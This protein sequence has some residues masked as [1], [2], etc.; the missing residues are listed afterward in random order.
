MEKL[1][2]SGEKY[3]V[4]KKFKNEGKMKEG[5]NMRCRTKEKEIK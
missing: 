2:E 1:R 4:E 5:E 3:N